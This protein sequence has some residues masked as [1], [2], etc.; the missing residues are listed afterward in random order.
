MAPQSA[1]IEGQ[2]QTS[3]CRLRARPQRLELIDLVEIDFLTARSVR[4]QRRCS[5]QQCQ[6]RDRR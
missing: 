5:E 4:P 1:R 2:K 6:T 3:D